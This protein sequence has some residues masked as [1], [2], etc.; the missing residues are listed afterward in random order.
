M[1]DVKNLLQKRHPQFCANYPR[2]AKLVIGALRKLFHEKQLQQFE[3]DHPHLSGFDFVEQALDYFNF[4]YR[5]PDIEGQRI[6]ARGKVVIVAN[7]PIGSLDSLAL[8][9]I[10]SKVRPD[11]K[12]VANKLLAI[13]K[14]LTP[15]LLLV[16][17]MDGKT[18]R[19]QLGAIHQHLEN[20]GALIIFPAGEVSRFGRKGIRDGQWHSGF[21]R[22]AS[23]ARAP[24]LPMFV[25]GRNSSFFYLLSWLALPLSTLWLVREMF[26]QRGQRIDIRIGDAISFRSYQKITVPLKEKVNLFQRHLYLIGQ[27]HTDQSRIGKDR[28]G[29]FTGEIAVAQPENRQQLRTEIHRCHRLGETSDNKHIYLYHYSQT[30]SC[31]MRE[32]GRL[33]ELSFRAVEEGSGQDRDL[34]D[35]DRHYQHLILWDEA[36]AEI[37]GAYRFCDTTSGHALYTQT[38]FQF[39]SGMR[40][41]LAQGLELGR[42][43]VQPKYWGKRSLN[44]LWFGIGAFLRENPQYRYLFGSVSLSAAYPRPALE[45]LVHFYQQHFPPQQA[46]A[47]PVDA[48]SISPTRRKALAQRFP[49]NDYRAEFRRLKRELANMG[50]SVP[51]L[52]KQYTEACEPEGVQFVGFNID[53]AFA[54]CIDGLMIIDLSRIK[55]EKR[56]RYL[57]PEPTQRAG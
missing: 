39:D 37:A 1:L 43:F 48:F 38:L 53:P 33:R 14:P 24:V 29:I 12:I 49:G 52:Y 26:K 31:I 3:C 30:D 35:F 51:T 16:D 23:A 4:V 22:I 32:I 10:V 6:P 19:K 17:N 50:L 27:D 57:E 18:T 55:A 36:E 21:L 54:D 44:Y 2:L 9:K 7:H 45:T 34:D 11:V 15:L 56:V 5:L 42:S 20:H 25:G 41:Y 40:P 46:I 47:A 28:A 8:L 13:V